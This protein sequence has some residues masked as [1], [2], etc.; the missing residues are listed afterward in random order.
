MRISKNGRM[1]IPSE[2]PANTLISREKD[3]YKGKRVN[4]RKGY[5]QTNDNRVPQYPLPHTD[6]ENE[7]N[8][9]SLEN[10]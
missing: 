8:H 2:G 5:H 1:I 4:N 10:R 7:L 9:Y 3:P 6:T